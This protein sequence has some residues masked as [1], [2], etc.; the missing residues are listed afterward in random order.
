[1]KCYGSFSVESRCSELPRV[2]LVRGFVDPRVPYINRQITVALGGVNTFSQGEIVLAPPLGPNCR[3]TF[4]HA[5]SICISSDL[6]GNSFSIPLVQKAT[7]S[8]SKAAQGNIFPG[9]G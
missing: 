7:L 5:F 3:G 4:S 2:Q 8:P 6:T 9:L 1:M